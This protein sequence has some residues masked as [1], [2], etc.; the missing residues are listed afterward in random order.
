MLTA[1]DILTPATDSGILP[2]PDDLHVNQTAAWIV[3]ALTAV[4]LVVT[5]IWTAEITRRTSSPLPVMLLISGAVLFPFYVEPVGDIILATW[6]P[7]DA[8]IIVATILGRHIPLFVVLGYAAGIP[9][10]CYVG[11]QMIV[12]GTPVRTLLLTLAGIS[13]SEGIIEMVAVHFGFM[14]YYGNHALIFGVPLSTLVQNAGMFVMIGVTLAWLLPK[15]HGLQWLVVPFVP[16]AVFGCYA[17]ACTMPT[18]YAIHGQL[19]PLPFWGVALLSTA[20]NAGVP[21]VALYSNTA[22]QYREQRLAPS[23][24]D[25][26]VTVATA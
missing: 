20:L 14:R 21:I 1:I 12:R 2:P 10:A 5:L 24:C 18:F 23:T 26:P 7:P 9:I 19:P 11:Y 8:P 3:I 15:L 13:I 4:S 6:Y 25:G 22:R 17:L 16:P